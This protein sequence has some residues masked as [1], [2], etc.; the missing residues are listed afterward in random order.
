MGMVLAGKAEEMSWVG[1]NSCVLHGGLA[2]PAWC[3]V[4]FQLTVPLGC[5]ISL[6]ICILNCRAS[7]GIAGRV[8]QSLRQ[9]VNKML[10]QRQRF[11]GK[12]FAG[13]A[14]HLSLGA[15]R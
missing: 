7:R 9:S 12:C 13:G 6:L 15:S 2:Q 10:R 14:S 11:D 1:K 4:Q 8:R 3:M 5:I